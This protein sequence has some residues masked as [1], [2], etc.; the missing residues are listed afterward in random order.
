MQLQFSSRVSTQLVSSSLFL[1]I[2]GFVRIVVNGLIW[3]GFEHIAC[4]VSDLLPICAVTG[5]SVSNERNQV[6]G[7]I[8]NPAG[9]VEQVVR[10]LIDIA[11]GLEVVTHNLE[12]FEDAIP[13]RERYGVDRLQKFAER[14]ADL[15]I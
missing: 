1:V 6:C 8:V 13:A 15:V 7:G 3:D 5:V 12:V 11:H 10:Q 4:A 14:G 9:I 2:L